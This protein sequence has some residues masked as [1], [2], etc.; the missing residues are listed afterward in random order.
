MDIEKLGSSR[1]LMGEILRNQGLDVLAEE[2]PEPG[3][4]G[5]CESTS[6][7][8]DALDPS[9]VFVTRCHSSG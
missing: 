1:N 2:V 3:I 5:N 7:H 9:A 6:S 4:C 8:I